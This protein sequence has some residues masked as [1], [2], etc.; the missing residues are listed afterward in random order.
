MRKTVD[1]ALIARFKK[2]QVLELARRSLTSVVAH[3]VLFAFVAVITPLKQDHPTVLIILGGLVFAISSVRMILAKKVPEHYDNAPARWGGTM[4]C[5]NC[6]S[7]IIWGVI[8]LLMA[9]Y[10]P[11]EWPFYVTLVISCGLA[12]GATSSLGPHLN[13][14]RI[15]TISMLSPISVWGII[16]GSSLGIAMAVLCAFSI[17]MYIR[18]ARDNYLWYWDSVASQEKI[19]AHTQ[20]V[21]TLF[22][23][24]HYNAESLNHASRDLSG[25]SGGMTENARDMTA[26]LSD[27]VGFTQKVNHNAQSMAAL[28]EQATGNFTNI[29][30]AT[31]EMSSTIRD[32]AGSTEK[33]QAITVRAVKQSEKAAAEMAALGESAQAI[34]Q[35]TQAIEDISAQINLLALNATIEAARAGEAGK[36][37]A[38]V[39]SEIKE[40]AIQTSGSAG[41]ITRQV[42]GIQEATNRSAREMDAITQVVKEANHRVSGITDAVEEQSAATN[43]VARNINE[44]SAG[45]NEVNR[46][47]G[48]NDENLNQ[49]ADYVSSLDTAAKGVEDGA[50]TVNDHAETLLRLANE[51]VRQKENVAN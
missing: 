30:S 36:G 9:V 39:A 40:L 31:E 45:F 3:F 26:K 43:E 44:A 17:F 47:M 34:N 48:E 13:L 12:A 16:N 25:F 41:E 27:V 4:F 46:M 42:R 37:F 29:A 50:A 21:E 35:I 19:Q 15:F 22:N 5:L 32:I 10:Y 24:M 18:M 6:V 23:G 11:L 51:M 49:V 1:G 14:S 33:T 28:M 2:E 20:T 8:G 38:V 7:G